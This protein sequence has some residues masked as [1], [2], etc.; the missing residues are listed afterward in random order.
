METSVTQLL[1][2]LKQGAVDRCRERVLQAAEKKPNSGTK[3]V[4]RDSS[5]RAVTA[6]LK[7]R[8]GL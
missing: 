2:K 3:E 1:E 8:R 5:Q 4:A 6:H 7:E